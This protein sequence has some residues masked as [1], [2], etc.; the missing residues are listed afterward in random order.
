MRE[1]VGEIRRVGNS[2]SSKR[3]REGG[4]EVGWLGGRDTWTDRRMDGLTEVEAG[5]EGG[6]ERRGIEWETWR[7]V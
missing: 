1:Q 6:K 7:E 5:T 3:E 4:K 2:G